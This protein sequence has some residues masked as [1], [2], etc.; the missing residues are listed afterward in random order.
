MPYILIVEDCNAADAIFESASGLTTTGATAFPDFYDFPK[1]LL[2]WRSLSQ[3]FGGLGVV[4]LF[5]ALLSCLGAGAKILFSNES[6]GASTDFD[7]GRIQSGAFALM[8]FYLGI[9]AACT[10]AYKFGGMDWFQAINHAM[11][12][13]ATGGFSTE[14]ISMEA[15]ASPTL[16]WISIIFM[17]GPAPLA[18]RTRS[19]YSCHH[20]SSNMICRYR[21]CNSPALLLGNSGTSVLR[22][23]ISTKE[24]KKK[25]KKKK[26][27]S[28]LSTSLH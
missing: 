18:S 26:K 27:S 5:V 7:H 24:K 2:F 19:K 4:V 15:F 11:T 6:S 16:E 22:Q 25:G 3:W 21:S 12:T 8:L 1:S 14:A 23:W 17:A 13:V 10:L 9:S 20:C 28:V